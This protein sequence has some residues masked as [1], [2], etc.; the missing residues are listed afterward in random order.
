HRRPLL[1]DG[2]VN[3]DHVAA[4]LV[5]DGVERQR[6]L[7]GLP[8]ADDQ[9]ALAAADGD[10]RVDGLNARLQGLFYRLPIDH[11]G[12]EAFHGIELGGLN[13]TFTVDRFADRVDHAADH[14]FADRD[15]HDA[16]RAAHLPP[17][18]MVC[19]GPHAPCPPLTLSWFRGGARVFGRK[20]INPPRHDLFKTV[21]AGN[22]VA[23]RNPRAGLADIDNA[24]VILNLLSQ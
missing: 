10:H 17:L 1:T 24:L 8:V 5:D 14:G 18:E 23:Y 16:R 4:L 19:V 13:R 11:A 6:R 22:A 20:L 15:R 21:N 9:L 3:A 7:A 2:D 12:R